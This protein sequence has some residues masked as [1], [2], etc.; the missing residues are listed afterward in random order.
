[1]GGRCGTDG[2]GGMNCLA[3]PLDVNWIVFE[4]VEEYMAAL[5]I[6]K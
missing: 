1:M 6:S 5:G 2:R 3:T 4:Q